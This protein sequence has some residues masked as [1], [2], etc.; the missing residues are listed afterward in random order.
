MLQIKALEPKDSFL[1]DCGDDDMNDFFHNDAVPHTEL[2]LAKTYVYYDTDTPNQAIGFFTVLNDS[3]KGQKVEQFREALPNEKRYPFF[4]AVKI[5]RLGRDSKFK[6]SKYGQKI[7]DDIKHSFTF[8]NKTGC[9]FITVDAYN[10]ENLLK[11]Y[12]NNGFIFLSDKDQNKETRVM[13]YNLL[14]YK[15]NFEAAMKARQ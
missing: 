13:Y 5:G 14:T 6:G 7:L 11:F 4:P 8:N 9:C 3:I 2:L 10:K 12:Q 15:K 1:F